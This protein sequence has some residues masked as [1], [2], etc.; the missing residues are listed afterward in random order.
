MQAGSG[1]SKWPI[2]ARDDEFAR[3]LAAA[4]GLG[5][6]GVVGRPT[7]GLG[8]G[9]PRPLRAGLHT[10]RLDACLPGFR[11]R[12]LAECLADF[13]E[14]LGDAGGWSSLGCSS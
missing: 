8:Q 11:M 12:S 5:P 9:A 2:V 7:V 1:G 13:R 14:R 10:P 4:F 6:D 3:A